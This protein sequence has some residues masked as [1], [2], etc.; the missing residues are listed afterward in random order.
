MKTESNTTKATPTPV[1]S[2]SEE[3]EDASIYFRVERDYRSYQWY[4][5]KGNSKTP[6]DNL[7]RPIF[8]LPPEHLHHSGCGVVGSTIFVLGGMD[9]TRRP[10]NNGSPDGYDDVYYIDTR[11]PSSGWKEGCPMTRPRQHPYAVT[12]D[13]LHKMYVFGG[14]R[15][16]VS[17]WA[18]VF[19]FDGN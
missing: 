12:V 19:D 7:L 6:E 13:D 11:R 1:S 9:S 4:V 18:E 10:Y 3:Y 2:S 14:I 17:P 8:P 15:H 5:I 16:G